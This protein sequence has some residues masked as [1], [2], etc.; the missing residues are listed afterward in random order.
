MTLRCKG[1]LSIGES[2]TST[3]MP[4]ISL[5]LHF[6]VH[7]KE[8]YEVRRII[9]YLRYFKQYGEIAVMSVESKRDIRAKMSLIF[10]SKNPQLAVSRER[11]G[12]KIRSSTNDLRCAV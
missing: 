1:T 6:C 3:Y 4:P 5:P 7:V 8:L 11:K 10:Y 12:G 9:E 2:E